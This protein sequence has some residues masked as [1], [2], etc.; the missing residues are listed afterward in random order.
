[1]VYGVGKTPFNPEIDEDRVTIPFDSS[2]PIDEDP[3]YKSLTIAIQKAKETRY[4]RK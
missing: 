1:M 2:S 3:E 4:P